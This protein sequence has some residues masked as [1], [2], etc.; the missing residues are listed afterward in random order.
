L[1]PLGLTAANELTV[2]GT[3]AAAA[4][5]KMLLGSADTVTA[6]AYSDTFGSGAAGVLALKIEP[7]T[8][9]PSVIAGVLDS[10]VLA[11]GINIAAGKTLADTEHTPG[12]V[13]G[14]NTARNSTALI[15]AN[16]ANTAQIHLL[17]HTSAANTWNTIAVFSRAT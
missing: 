5:G 4:Q 8:A 15:S 12:L 3:A 10:E 6:A 13:F 2:V 11:G 16:A 1:A 9:L 7:P 14:L 17:A